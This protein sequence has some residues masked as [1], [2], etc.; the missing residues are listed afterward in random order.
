VTVVFARLKGPVADYLARGGASAAAGPAIVYLEVDDAVAA[1]RAVPPGTH[2]E[3][4]Q[5]ATTP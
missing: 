3:T 4:D 1:F 2:R 5:R